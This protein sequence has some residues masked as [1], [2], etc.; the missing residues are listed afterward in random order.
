MTEKVEL[1]IEELQ[2]LRA[3]EYY[4]KK[5][6]DLRGWELTEKNEKGKEMPLAISDEEYEELI[7]ASSGISS[8]NSRNGVAK[9]LEGVSLTCLALG[10]VVGFALMAFKQNLGFVW[11]TVSILVSFL[12]YAV[13]KGLSEI[14]K[15]LQRIIDSK[16]NEKPAETRTADSQ[17][18]APQAQV[19]PQPQQYQNYIQVQ[20]QAQPQY[21]VA[22]TTPAPPQYVQVTP[23]YQPYVQQPVQY[24]QPV[25]QPIPPQHK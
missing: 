3:E 14:L 9:F 24:Q 11:F 18:K 8:L 5:D 22:Y 25:Q 1:K 12:L 23:P 21:Q 7:K 17:V 20:P 2:K 19:Q 10:I 16:P 4:R 6:A 15:L 13:F